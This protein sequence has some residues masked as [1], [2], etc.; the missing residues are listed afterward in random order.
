M[1][2]HVPK[3]PGVPQMLKDG[4]RVSSYYITKTT[5]IRY[6]HCHVPCGKQMIHKTFKK[7]A[8]SIASCILIP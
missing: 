1:A 4:A 6:L 7:Y 2:L 3:A 5:I 8:F